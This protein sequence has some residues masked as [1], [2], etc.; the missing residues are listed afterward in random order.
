MHS[1]KIL[2]WALSLSLPLGSAFADSAADCDGKYQLLLKN[3]KTAADKVSA[4]YGQFDSPQYLKYIGLLRDRLR[5]RLQMWHGHNYPIVAMDDATPVKAYL[6][7]T[8]AYSF[9]SVKAS[10]FARLEE[11]KALESP[12]EIK[13]GLV[14]LAG[15]IKLYPSEAEA[16]I[17]MSEQLKTKESFSAAMD[18]FIKGIEAR[19]APVISMEEIRTEVSDLLKKVEAYPA[20]YKRFIDETATMSA[21]ADALEE[22]IRRGDHNAHGIKLQLPAADVQADG[23]V[24]MSMREEYFGTDVQMK[25]RLKELKE[26]VVNR[27]AAKFF[28][29]STN[30]NLTIQQAIAFKK[31]ETFRH[32]L[33]RHASLNPGK[34]LTEEM[35]VVLNRLYALYADANAI[36]LKKDYRLPYWAWDRLRWIQLY[37]E[38]RSVVEKDI[39]KLR[40]MEQNS[41]VLEFLK[42]LPEEDKRAL[43]L[44]RISESLSLWSRTNWG[45]VIL[46]TGTVAAGTGTGVWQVGTAAYEYFISDGRA[47]EACASILNDEDFINCTQEYLQLKFPKKSIAEILSHKSVFTNP[48]GS[49]ADDEVAKVVKDILK[50]RLA[51]QET[52][53]FKTNARE[54]LQKALEEI[55]GEHDMS[56]VAYRKK[57][58]ETPNDQAFHLAIM[59]TDSGANTPRIRSYLEFR[60]PVHY[61]TYKEAVKNILQMEYNSE[62]QAKALNELRRRG[63]ISLSDEIKSLL[64]ER[65]SFKENGVVDI[66]DSDLSAEQKRQREE[67]ERKRE[68]EIKRRKEEEEK[69]RN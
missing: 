52:E 5:K 7:A 17:R 68:E 51:F 27:T 50:R 22:I 49:I 1:K 6:F 60:F 54:A 53:N 47:R 23:S 33:M 26:Q 58:V 61:R 46:G 29:L 14:E 69:R 4:R 42:N 3:A 21:Q 65:Q 9:N 40:D 39:P 35:E 24:V 64:D 59:G 56:S 36:K 57:M 12:E 62:D 15:R 32:E 45:T 30:Q 41:K 37:G 34:K 19:P 2:F 8:D 48:E 11:L 66:R 20:E 38:V 16:L 28:T 25:L 13:A 31:L 63:A 10:V 18:D 67:E 55:M 43:G 44:G